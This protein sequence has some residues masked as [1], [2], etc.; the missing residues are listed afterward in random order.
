MVSQARQLGLDI[1]P[2]D[3]FLLQ[4]IEQLADRV[5]QWQMVEQ[6]SVAL[7]SLTEQQVQALPWSML[8]SMAFTACRLCSRACCSSASTAALKTSCTS[9]S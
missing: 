4:T 2:R 6:Q 9:T 3:L 5:G 7:H 8:G 1:A